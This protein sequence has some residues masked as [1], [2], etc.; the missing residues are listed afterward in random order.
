M[1]NARINI[2]ASGGNSW[3]SREWSFSDAS[4]YT[5][6]PAGLW[7]YVTSVFSQALTGN[8][9]ALWKANRISSNSPKHDNN[10]SFVSQDL[11][12]AN[13]LNA[14]Q[15]IWFRKKY[16]L[17]FVRL[18]MSF[19]PGQRTWTCNLCFSTPAGKQGR[20]MLC[21]ASDKNRCFCLFYCL[22]SAVYL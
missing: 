1:T 2:R 21:P 7:K 18:I 8:K 19:T 13:V 6:F 14:K 12:R 16:C 10:A 4:H 5:F 15:A 20:P 11:I 17:V 3:P 9:S 22:F